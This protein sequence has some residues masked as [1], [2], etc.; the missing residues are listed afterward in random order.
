MVSVG[1]IWLALLG[2]AWTYV[3]ASPATPAMTLNFADLA[4][5]N[6]NNPSGLQA[7]F[8][9]W[10]A[11]AFAASTTVVV[12]VAVR[13][14]NRVGGLLCAVT[15]TVQLVLTL[16]VMVEAAPDLSA[17]VAGLPYARLGTVLFLGSMAALGYSGLRRLP[18][19]DAQPRG[20][21]PRPA[22]A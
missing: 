18:T 3:P 6:A 20:G 9:H 16:F 8:Y 22:A 2:P 4:V 5:L 21:V 11:W 14:G 12:L 10:V 13:A 17:L 15:G 7:A 1:A 19:P